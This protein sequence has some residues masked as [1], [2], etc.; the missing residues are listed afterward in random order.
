M[1]V[2]VQK[3][4]EPNGSENPVLEQP[5][6]ETHSAYATVGTLVPQGVEAPGADKVQYIA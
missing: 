1:I 3:Q 2:V 4:Y 5:P 6:D